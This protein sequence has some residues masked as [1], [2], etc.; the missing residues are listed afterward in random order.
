MCNGDIKIT[1]HMT[2]GTCEYC[3]SV[4]TLPKIDDD[5]R[6]ALFNR[7]NHSRCNRVLDFEDNQ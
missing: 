3:G 4:Q 2:L 5:V 7:G 1:N 6:V